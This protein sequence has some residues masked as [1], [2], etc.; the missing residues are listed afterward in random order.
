MLQEQ[1]G[2]SRAVLE[3]EQLLFL[4]EGGHLLAPSEI[5]SKAEARGQARIVN[6]FLRV[7]LRTSPSAT[8]QSTLILSRLKEEL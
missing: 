3:A 1:L 8:G 2:H 7:A 5:A 6:R 4:S